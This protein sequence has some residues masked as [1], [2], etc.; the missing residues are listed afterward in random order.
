MCTRQ[1]I[2]VRKINLPIAFHFSFWNSL[3]WKW[4]PDLWH[5]RTG[6]WEKQE[7]IPTIGF[8]T[9]YL[10]ALFI[11][12]GFFPKLVNA[13]AFCFPWSVCDGLTFPNSLNPSQ[14]LPH[15]HLH[16]QKMCE[17]GLVSQE[18]QGAWSLASQHHRQT[19]FDTGGWK[20]FVN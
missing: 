10:L 15:S 9:L 19:T 5:P 11:I 14:L 12:W 8:L 13:F 20:Y 16:P 6:S 1:K 17:K 7:Y 3:R 4:A 2:P 18:G